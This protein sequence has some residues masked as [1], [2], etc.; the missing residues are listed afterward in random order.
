LLRLL[1]QYFPIRN[2]IFFVLEGCIIF[3]SVLLASAL[4]TFSP[5]YWFDFLLGLRILLVT[6]ICQICLYYNDLYDF[7]VSSSMGEMVIRLLQALGITSI[8]L[9]VI[10]F[11]FP[12]AIIDQKVF[13]LSILFLLIFI[14]GWR[15]AYLQILKK[16]LFNEHIIILGSSDLAFAIIEK[17]N[18]TLDC[19]YTVSVLIPDSAPE[20]FPKALPKKITI[21]QGTQKLCETA[22]ATGINKIIVA[23]RE[24]RGAFPTME[25]LQCRT[26]GI[27]I[28]EGSTFYEMLTGKVLVKLINPSWLIFSDGFR[29]SRWKAAFK[30]I[31]DIVLSF[32]ML[33]LL[34]PLLLLTAI[35]IKL[36]SKGPVFFSQDRVGLNKEEYMMHKFRSMVQD[37]E[38]TTGPVWAQTNDL[39]ITRV[40][41]VIRKF[42][43]DELPQLWNVFAGKMSM[44]GPRPERRHFTEDLEKQIP[45]YAQR[46]N[47]KPGLTG[48]AQVCYDYG[49]TLD[50]AVEKLNYELFYIKNMSLA[51]DMVIILRTVKTVLFGRGAR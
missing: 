18:D 35:L 8:S 41:R 12:L 47:V 23:L 43:I 22:A 27:E 13:I 37:A 7:E 3:S 50:D 17:I 42:R 25:L 40:G 48:W 15:L 49:A 26:D 28:I 39:R 44:V 38:K 36:D 14:I 5:S 20:T 46:F 1:K 2:I 31:Q 16:G 24:K 29:K 9:A 11:I 51:M 19:G 21:R 45:F 10:Y 32:V 34:F 30:R 6:L 4:V 33:V